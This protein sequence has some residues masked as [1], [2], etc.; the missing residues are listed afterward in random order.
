VD[1]RPGLKARLTKATQ[2][3]LGAQRNEEPAPGLHEGMDARRPN[4]RIDSYE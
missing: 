2:M 3:E 1:R 4:S